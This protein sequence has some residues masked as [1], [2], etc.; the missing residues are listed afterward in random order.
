MRMLVGHKPQSEMK[1]G[2]VGGKSGERALRR[3]QRLRPMVS[4]PRRR[5]A[6]ATGLEAEHARCADALPGGVL[7]RGLRANAVADRSRRSAVRGRTVHRQRRERLAAELSHAV[8]Q[9]SLHLVAA[10]GG[11]ELAADRARGD[12]AA[13]GAL[14]PDSVGVLASVLRGHAGIVCAVPEF[15]WG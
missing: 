13:G 15:V 14:R 10:A 8:D 5:S 1:L 6:S 2:K 3:P 4:H 11:S 7:V 9:Q 12:G